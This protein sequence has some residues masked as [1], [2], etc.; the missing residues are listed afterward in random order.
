MF[1]ILN[2][3]KP[4]TKI[5]RRKYI[6]YCIYTL[7]ITIKYTYFVNLVC[8]NKLSTKFGGMI[9]F[10]FDID[11]VEQSSDNCLRFEFTVFAGGHCLEPLIILVPDFLQITFQ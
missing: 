9:C 1:V 3:N 10:T 4:N 7:K 5:L 11:L 6:I 2:F 8:L